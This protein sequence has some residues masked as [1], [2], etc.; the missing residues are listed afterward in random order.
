[1]DITVQSVRVRLDLGIYDPINNIA[2][3]EFTCKVVENVK[4]S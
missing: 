4:L 3:R 2:I 1:M